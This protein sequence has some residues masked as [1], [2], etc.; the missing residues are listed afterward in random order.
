M[1]TRHIK[2]LTVGVLVIILIAFVFQMVSVIRTVNDVPEESIY[3]DLAIDQ[4]LL[5]QIQQ[6]EDSITDRK[7]FIFTVTRDPLEQN[8]VVST[9]VDLELEWRRKVESMM[10]LAATYIDEQGNR[11][12]SIAYRGKMELYDVGDYIED[13]RIVSIESGTITLAQNG[14]EQILE[15][16]PIPPKPAQ[17]DTERRDRREEYVW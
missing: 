6:I 4:Q 8:I 2:D 7:G 5:E 10:R 3:K 16:K 17:I 13:N 15:V 14:R 12:A 9:R 11:R 1:E